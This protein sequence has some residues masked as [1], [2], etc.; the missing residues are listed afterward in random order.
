MTAFRTFIVRSTLLF[1]GAAVETSP[2]RPHKTM[3]CPTGAVA[4]TA[5]V[6]LSGSG[7]LGPVAPTAAFKLMAVVWLSGSGWL[8]AVAPTAAFR[9]MAGELAESGFV[10]SSGSD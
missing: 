1:H 7:W 5:V 2:G 4:P 3:V 10:W 9:L 8:R 6:R